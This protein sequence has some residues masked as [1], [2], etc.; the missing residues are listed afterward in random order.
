VHNEK[1]TA[2]GTLVAGVAHEINNPLTALQLS[3]SAC[4][5][6][7]TPLSNIAREV[8]MLAGRGGG[9]SPAQLQAL[10]DAARTGA[11]A[12][13]TQELLEEMVIASRAIADVVRDLRVFARAEGNSEEPQVL[14]L[15]DF[16]DQALRLVGRE[17]ESHGRVERDY[18][19]ELPQL[20]APPG[21]LTQVLVNI[22]VNAAQAIREVERP[23]HRVR[24]TLRA[25][26]DDVAISVT[27]TGP[28]V[29]PAAVERIFDPFFT[30]K[31]AGAGT[32][33]GLSISRSI[34]R[35][36]GGDLIVESVHGEGATFVILVPV[37]DAETLR[38]AYFRTRG[39]IAPLKALQRAHVMVVDDDER[40]LRAYAR[41]LGRSCNVLMAS[42]GREAIELL[43]SGSTA[44][45]LVTELSL[46]DVNG[47]ELFEWVTRE[48]PRLAG[49][50][51]FV[52]AESTTVRFE[53]FLRTLDNP[54]LMKPVTAN[55][56]L[57]TIDRAVGRLREST[58]PPNS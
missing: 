56:L 52:T 27:D 49:R 53:P 28:G 17:I 19:P 55:H 16:V 22:L 32:G 58:L 47:Q 54:I 35:E 1:L 31:R 39:P 29:S 37:P 14:D 46:P 40:V 50:T 5:A 18:A 15:A 43:S 44:D 41:V 42:D 45:A 10:H 20:V 13:E 26:E 30:T 4:H 57:S 6:L 23:S 24:I 3:V 12:R 48:H 36:M 34:M 9:A 33:L 7:V 8:S 38:K 21:R 25:D 51:I 2:L 11:P